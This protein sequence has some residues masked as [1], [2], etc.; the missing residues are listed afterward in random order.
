MSRHIAEP[1]NP[2]SLLHVPVVDTVMKD[3]RIAW[4]ARAVDKK[5]AYQ[6]VVSASNTG[7]R[8]FDGRIFYAAHSRT[9]SWLA[10]QQDSARPL[11]ERDLW[12]DELLFWVH[13]YLHAWSAALI[14]RL[15]P[16]LDF[17]SALIDSDN[18]EPLV[19]AHLLT[20]AVATVG[21]DNW[22]LNVVDIN[23]YCP[24]GTMK[25]QL[26]VNYRESELKEYRRYMPDLIVQ[27][28][29]FFTFMCDVYCKGQWPGIDFDDL[30]RSPRLDHWVNKE[31]LYG[32]K[33]REYAR[34]WLAHLADAPLAAEP[35]AKPVECGAPWQRNLIEGV[36]EALWHLLKNGSLEDDVDVAPDDATWR[37]PV[38]RDG[39]V[40]VRFTSILACSDRELARLEGESFTKK[41]FALIAGQHL[42]QFDYD[43]FPEEKFD[44][45]PAV[46]EAR[47]FSA[48]RRLTDGEARVASSCPE[49]RDL[50]F[51]P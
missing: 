42:L 20:E 37:A 46:F 49:E 40:D 32:E 35:A 34:A 14:R 5:W 3:E 26:A 47:G 9:A 7:F 22:F 43:R 25:R 45:L 27:E 15:A 6:G 41:E 28:P 51:L 33:Q 4:Q 39:P 23:D 16:Q 38:E 1:L 8:P 19:F 29:N 10:R 17:G 36:G 48:L 44:R 12:L 13:D 30:V 21:L 50:F 2:E 24:I 18:F 31:L 11:N